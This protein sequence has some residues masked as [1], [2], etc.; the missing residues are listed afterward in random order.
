MVQ[1]A[2]TI[3]DF[4]LDIK[5]RNLRVDDPR[6]YNATVDWPEGHL[7]TYIHDMRADS[8]QEIKNQI[9]TI[10]QQLY[11]NVI[12]VQVHSMGR[13]SDEYIEKMCY[14]LNMPKSRISNNLLDSVLK[15][16]AEWSIENTS[17]I[18]WKR[19]K[20]NQFEKGKEEA[21]LFAEKCAEHLNWLLM[22]SER[23]VPIELGNDLTKP[24]RLKPIFS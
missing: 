15:M 3:E 23:N 2:Y 10:F 9:S 1:K 24:N 13:L 19:G 7:G 8:N 18:I 5:N 17:L 22:E 4:I 6:K 21:F 11:N 12:L 20:E 16:V 14:D